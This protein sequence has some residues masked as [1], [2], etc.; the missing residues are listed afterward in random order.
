MIDDR[1]YVFVGTIRP[2]YSRV[3][4]ELMIMMIIDVN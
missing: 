2:R 4:E 1:E 3:L